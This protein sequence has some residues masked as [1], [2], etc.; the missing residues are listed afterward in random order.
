M[1]VIVSPEAKKILIM[2]R[3]KKKKPS[4][5]GKDARKTA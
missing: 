4:V 2:L 5:P 3:G 1:K